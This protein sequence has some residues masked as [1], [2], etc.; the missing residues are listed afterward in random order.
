[1]NRCVHIYTI[2]GVLFLLWTQSS[3]AQQAPG[4]NTFQAYLGATLIHYDFEEFD[5][6]D[7]ALVREKG[8][9]PGLR[10]GLAKSFNDWFIQGDL[11][12][13]KG[14]IRYDG[15]TQAGTPITTRTD[16]QILDI[17]LLSGYQFTS[18]WNIDPT[19]YAGFGYRYWERDIRSTATAAGLSETYTWWYGI[20]GLEGN[21]YRGAKTHFKID[22]RITRTVNPEIEVDFNNIFDDARLELGERFGLRF[23]MPFHVS[24]FENTDFSLTPFFEYWE[25]GRSSTEELLRQGKVIGTIFEPRS[26]T[27]ILGIAI[28]LNRAF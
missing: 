3:L 5:D 2:L 27:R 6:N 11:Q 22:L 19:L 21:L 1:M 23:S 16:E 10:S 13:F 7:A 12:Y 25:L 9:L 24:A 18:L 17:S 26:E 20:V 8:A 28:V 15:Q 14:D 4:E